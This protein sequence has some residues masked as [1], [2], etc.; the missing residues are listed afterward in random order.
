M[1]DANGNYRFAG[2]PD[3]EYTICERLDLQPGWVQTF[4]TPAFGG[5]ACPTGFGWTFSMA[6]WSASFVN[7]SNVVAP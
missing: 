2:L 4:P 3:G 1:T 6:G 7:F 5:V